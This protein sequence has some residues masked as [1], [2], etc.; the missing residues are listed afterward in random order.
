MAGTW[1]GAHYSPF[2]PPLTSSGIAP[3]RMLAI[4]A[5]SCRIVSWT[6]ASGSIGS[7]EKVIT[8][9]CRILLDR[10]GEHL[11]I[12]GQVKRFEGLI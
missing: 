4:D 8:P 10:T 5:R 7:C 9:A 11:D 6:I 2:L 1:L 12:C 3:G